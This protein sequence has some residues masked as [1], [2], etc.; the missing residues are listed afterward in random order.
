MIRYERLKEVLHYD[1]ESGIFTWK[2]R[3]LSDFANERAFKVFKIRFEGKPAG[4]IKNKTRSEKKYLVIGI[5]YVLYRAHRLAWFYMNGIMPE[6]DAIDHINGNGL[7]NRIENLRDGIN[8]SRNM[9]LMKTNSSGVSGVNWSK[10]KGKWR[11]R[12]HDGKELHL[13]YFD[14]FDSAVAARKAAELS[15]GYEKE[16]GEQRPF[17]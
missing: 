5:D 11:A 7:D 10:S 15:F 14:D 1:G 9:R 8:N 3:P 2:P 17:Y 16:H 12:I 6:D 4:C 13:G